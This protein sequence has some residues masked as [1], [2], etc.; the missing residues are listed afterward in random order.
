[1]TQMERLTGEVSGSAKIAAAGICAP[2]P[3]DSDSGTVIGIST[4]PGW[5][6]VPLRDLMSKRL[7][8]PV[9]LENDGIAAANG[10][11]R[12]GAARNLKHL[13]YVTVSTGIGGGVVADGKLLRGRRGMAGHVGHMI[14][15][16]DGPMCTCGAR[17]C[18]EALA[19]GSALGA[20]GRLA[21]ADEKVTAAA[22][23]AAA[24]GG[25]RVALDLLDTFARRLGIGFTSLMHLYSPER[26][27]MGG[28]VAHAFDLMAPRIRE[29]VAANTMAPFRDVEIVAAALGDNAGLVGVAALAL[30]AMPSAV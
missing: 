30:A 12:F 25:N 26:L 24:R 23:T 19:S 9:V 28:G 8:L 20:A 22:V 1:M 11:W 29:T 17:G 13:V 21:L 6:D 27:V 10:E 2:G 18:F 16:P 7:G 14:V 5:E 15:A 3:L 4:M